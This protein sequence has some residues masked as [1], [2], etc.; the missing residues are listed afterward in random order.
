MPVGMNAFNADV[1]HNI[2]GDVY[3]LQSEGSD[4]VPDA[5]PAQSPSVPLPPPLPISPGFPPQHAQGVRIVPTYHGSSS[6]STMTPYCKLL[7]NQNVEVLI[8][9]RG[10]VVGVII[11]VLKAIDTVTNWGYKVEY[12]SGGETLQKDFPAS[13]VRPLD[14]K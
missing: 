3:N 9:A 7:T 4:N 14:K 8:G 2:K 5:Y 13:H 1:N 10:W 6:L 11:G 12:K